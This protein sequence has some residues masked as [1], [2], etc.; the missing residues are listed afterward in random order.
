LPDEPAVYPRLKRDSPQ[1]QNSSRSRYAKDGPVAVAKFEL[2]EEPETREE[3][4]L[5]QRRAADIVM[6]L[7]KAIVG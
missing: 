6:R 4:I 7:L 3:R 5:R 1:R 2:G